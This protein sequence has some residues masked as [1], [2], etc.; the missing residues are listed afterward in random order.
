[1]RRLFVILVLAMVAGGGYHAAQDDRMQASSEPSRLKELKAS[2]PAV[3]RCA[4]GTVRAAGGA[5]TTD[6]KMCGTQDNFVC[7]G[8][9]ETC[10]VGRNNTYVCAT[11]GRCPSDATGLASEP[12]SSTVP[13]FLR[14]ADMAK[15]Q[16]SR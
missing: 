2:P 6:Q 8:P 3:T 13:D 5:C 12:L 9:R 14:V 10:C 7:C 4:D 11:D 16:S 1:M 15:R